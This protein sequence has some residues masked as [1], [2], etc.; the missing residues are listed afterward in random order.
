VFLPGDQVFI[1]TPPEVGK[2]LARKLR[3]PNDPRSGPHKIISKHGPV[4]YK[5]QRSD[6]QDKTQIVHARRLKLHVPFEGIG[7]DI[8]ERRSER[9][10]PEEESKQVEQ[11]PPPEAPPLPIQFPPIPPPRVSRARRRPRLPQPTPPRRPRRNR[12]PSERLR[13][14]GEDAKLARRWRRRNC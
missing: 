12:V 1:R 14:P 10:I 11:N 3:R 8:P 5:L 4:T 13:Y 2:G 7:A 6:K 9:Q